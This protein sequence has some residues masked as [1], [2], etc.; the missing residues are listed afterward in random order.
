VDEL[1]NKVQL[2]H[3]ES[4]WFILHDASRGMRSQIGILSNVTMYLIVSGSGGSNTVW[5]A[6]NTVFIEIQI[7]A[8]VASLLDVARAVGIKVFETRTPSLNRRSFPANID[9][10]LAIVQRG[11][12]FWGGHPP[13]W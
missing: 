1:L 9:V 4:H 12:D 10:M 8:C 3:P 13:S 2:A 6:R 11:Y 7:W 5:M